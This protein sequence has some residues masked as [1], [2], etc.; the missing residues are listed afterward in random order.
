[1]EIGV[2]FEQMG[3]L[4]AC[5]R[6]VEDSTSLLTGVVEL[7]RVDVVLR[8]LIVADRVQRAQDDPAALDQVDLRPRQP[9]T[10]S[11]GSVSAGQTRSTGWAR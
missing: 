2:H 11:S 4:E 1:V 3:R 5:D 6:A 9:R 10:S 7:R 8:G